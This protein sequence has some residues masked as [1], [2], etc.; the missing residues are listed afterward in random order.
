MRKLS[1]ANMVDIT[2]PLAAKLPP[3]RLPVETIALIEGGID[4]LNPKLA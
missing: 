2:K 1:E 3:S 4:R